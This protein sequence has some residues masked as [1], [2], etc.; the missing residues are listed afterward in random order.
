[1]LHRITTDSELNPNSNAIKAQE[2]NGY[3]K[4]N[5]DSQFAFIHEVDVELLTS[6]YVVKEWIT[7]GSAIFVFAVNTF[8][9]LF[10]NQNKIK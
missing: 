1:M 10:N 9:N 2:E 5:K 7:G 8:M 6:G 4:S 3:L